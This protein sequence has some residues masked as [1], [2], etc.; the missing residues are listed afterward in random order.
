MNTLEKNAADFLNNPIASYSRLAEQLNITNPRSDGVRWTKDSAYH[1]CR[2]HGIRSPRRCR[3]QPHAS[4]T[5]RTHKRRSIIQQLSDALLASGTPLAS[6]APFNIGEIARLSGHSPA[7][8]KS[9]WYRLEPEL[10]ALA[11][12]PPKPIVLGMFS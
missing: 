4:I 7:T 6:L 11:G 9:N 12:L 3:N 2:T 10:L 1:F 5:Q 8:I